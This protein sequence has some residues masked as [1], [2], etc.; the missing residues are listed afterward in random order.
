MQISW[1]CLKKTPE[2]YCL[3]VPEAISLK[4]SCQQV[5]NALSDASEEN[6]SLPLIASAVCQQSWHSLASLQSYDHLCLVCLHIVFLLCTSLSKFLLF[7][8]TLV[9]FRACHDDLILTWLNLQRPGSGLRK[10]A[11]QEA[12][13]SQIVKSQRENFESSKSR[14]ITYKGIPIRL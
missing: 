9:I 10:M 4:A 5:K 1:G 11:E 8:R 14:V 12:E 2:I 6:L 7:I 3:M 13:D